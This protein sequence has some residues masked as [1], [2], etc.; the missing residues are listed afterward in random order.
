M[1]LNGLK[2]L[3]MAS[4]ATIVS[5]LT[6]LV[7][8]PL[9]TLKYGPENYALITLFFTIIT[10]ISILDL[11]LPK[12]IIPKIANK[13]PFLGFLFQVFV[14]FSL[15]LIILF[16]VVNRIPFLINFFEGLNL[17]LIILASLLIFFLS[18]VRSILEGIKFVR[19]SIIS[20]NIDYVVQILA[21]YFIGKSDSFDSS[22]KIYLIFQILHFIVLT[23]IVVKKN[24][25]NYTFIFKNKNEFIIGILLMISSFIGPILTTFER[26]TW[27]YDESLIT[28]ASYA[29]AFT[30]ASRIFLF[31][32]ILQ[33]FI[34][35]KFSEGSIK[36]KECSRTS[37]VLFR[38]ITLGFLL[39]VP[40]IIPF[41]LGAAYKPEIS[42]YF[43]IILIGIYFNCLARI[44]YDYLIIIGKTKKLSLMHI[45][46]LI[47]IVPLLILL[48]DNDLIFIYL[49][50]IRYFIEYIILIIL[51]K[52]KLS[53]NPFIDLIIISFLIYI[54]TEISSI[55]IL[56]LLFH[57][58]YKFFKSHFNEMQS[59]F[60]E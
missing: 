49:I 24:S 43:K 42:T 30:I 56:F 29:L 25:I 28:L 1:R 23:L 50:S 21:L 31:S 51:S 18:S 34:F 40:Y 5:T 44:P 39:I 26:Y 33:Q 2:N 12:I 60:S 35:V 45:A 19:Y 46:E 32:S 53:L 22:I 11:G 9:I 57:Q 52:E 16:Y 54:P 37:T 55:L 17:F 4:I 36:L 47:F 13:E 41:W 48:R 7:F 27:K 10:Q 59:M 38:I 6:M 14:F 8:T 20:K 58:I 15:T 3:A